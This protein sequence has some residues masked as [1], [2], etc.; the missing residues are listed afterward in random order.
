M[1]QVLQNTRSGELSIATVPEPQVR[2][3]GVVVRNRAS[4]ISAGTEKAVID[5]AGR[6]MLGKA[7]ERPDLVRQVLDKVRRDGVMPTV[8]TVLSRLDQP[9]PLG[10]SCAGV[11]EQVGRGAGEFAP[12]DRVACAGMG[13]ASHADAVFVPRN[14]A[15]KIP[16]GVCFDDAAWVTLGAIALHGVRTAEV[17]LGDAVAVIGLGLLGQLAVQILRASGCRVIGIDR[18][19]ART[20]L[21]MELGAQAAV[22]RGEDVAGA[23]RAFTDGVGAD[24]VIIAAATTSNDPLELAGELC[25]DRAV[26]TVVG[27]VRMD[28]PRKVFYDRELQLRL[29]RS[30]GPGR[31]D[32]AY[33]ERGQDYPIGYVRWTERRNM[34]EFLR[35]VATGQVTPG[36]LVTHT[37]PIG[38]AARAY[39]I[40]TGRDPQPFMG[41]LLN[42]PPPDGPPLRTVTLDAGPGGRR[43]RRAATD[44]VG[45]GFI[46][47]GNFARAVLL[48]RFAAAA[49]AELV[50][51]AT[52]T[53]MN[54]AATGSRHG[55]RYAT[56]D[57]EQLLRDDDIDAVVIATRHGSH[58]RFAA[59]ALRAGKAVLLEKPLAITEAGLEEVLLAQAES[60]AL[61][62]IGFNRRF[63]PLAGRVRDFFPAG[64]PLAVQY[65]INAGAIP[66]DD[67]IHDPDD[68]GG[69]IIGEVCHFVDLIDYITGEAPVEV[70]AWSVGG[71]TAGLH[72][73]VAITLRLAGGSV[74]SINYF[75]TGDRAHGKEHLEVFGDGGIAILDDFR[76]LTLTRDGRRRR[77][78]HMTQDKGFDQEIAA[79]LAAVRS[80]GE[81][82]IPLRALATTT[83]ATFAIEESL[84]TGRPVLLP[85]G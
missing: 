1:K 12:G 69:R 82:P 20:A 59:D 40:V 25:R 24:A 18:D 84:R 72:D 48:P 67:W 56:T 23:V 70:F 11:V 6:S 50:G 79:F 34:Q 75:A 29:S 43:A 19:P 14:L 30:Y 27:T 53:G 2:S 15:V 9:L 22:L 63:S 33:E 42:Y 62:A 85:A 58:A 83:R 28:V 3:G 73:T 10:Y 74:A 65:R 8:Q 78:R 66:A 13:Y 81:P 38:E 57:V 44:R 31:Y 77:V 4:L 32:P 41:V 55:F 37:F 16:D 7:R 47:A 45:V 26:V 80:G 17:R 76:R 35:L 36:R 68:G 54:A 60:G 5:F 21:A 46:G 51:V 61:L 49:D 39:D 64:Q 52:A 71:P